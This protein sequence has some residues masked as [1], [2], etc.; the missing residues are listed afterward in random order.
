M[1]ILS[2]RIRELSLDRAAGRIDATVILTLPGPQGWHEVRVRTSAPLRVAGAA[3]L[4]ERL[5]ASAKLLL[6]ERLPPQAWGAPERARPA[7]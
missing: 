3:P 1:R 6:A 7:A 4:R 5:T 2:S